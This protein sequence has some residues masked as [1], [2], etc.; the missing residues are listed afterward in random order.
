MKRTYLLAA[1]LA[2][3]ALAVHAQ[4]SI[5]IAL[6]DIAGVR[7]GVLTTMKTGT[8]S[9]FRAAGIDLAWVDCAVAGKP[10]KNAECA[11]PLGPTRFMLRLVPGVNKTMPGVAGLAFVKDGAGVLA[12]LYPERTR[13]LARD[14]GWDFGD[15]LGHSAAHE[16]G[17]LVLRS[18]AHTEGG[19][20]RPRWEAQDLRRLSHAGLIFLPGQLRVVLA[21]V[22]QK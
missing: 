12:C 22:V 21:E 19:L 14:S 4:A 17:H 16:L 3:S 1:N 5:T 13:E 8:S 9:I 15:L 11:V 18:E 2:L 6:Y 10:V 20:M 7:P